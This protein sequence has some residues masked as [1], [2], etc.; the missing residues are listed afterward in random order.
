[1]VSELPESVF[2]GTPLVFFGEAAAEAAGELRVE[3]SAGDRQVPVRI[4]SS[5][6]GETLRLLTGARMIA[7][8]E[9]RVSSH[10]RE[11]K[12]VALR[13]AELSETY[14][15]ASR[16]MAL[17]AVVKRAGD[18]AGD[19]P[20]TVIVP[21]GMPQDTD[22][23]SS[24]MAQAPMQSALLAMM[25]AS[26]PVAAPAGGRG[27]LRRAKF[28]ISADGEQSAPPP[29]APTADDLL[30]A[31]A[32]MI[33]PDGGM[34]GKSESERA[35]ATFIALACFAAEGHTEKRGAFRSHVKRLVRYL[36]GLRKP[37]V[38]AAL[39]R[40]DRIDVQLE[41]WRDMGES[42]VSGGRVDLASVLTKI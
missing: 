29:P 31:L 11:E 21:V 12:R 19:V 38:D 30:L 6:I 1:V 3:W 8:L 13:I 18:R 14:G 24:F 25:P 10:A 4:G 5:A 26:P 33:L 23:A 35:A 28:S 9:S 27:L 37:E 39:A 42:L 32:S 34:P 41:I 22:F 7:D 36:K 17:V 40:L 2:A 16:S 15:L 20:K